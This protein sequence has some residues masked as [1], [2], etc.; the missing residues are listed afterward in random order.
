MERLAPS[1]Q[2]E[3][4]KVICLDVRI[5]N[6][7]GEERIL[8]G[9]IRPSGNVRFRGVEDSNKWSLFTMGKEGTDQFREHSLNGKVCVDG[10]F[11]KR[12][13]QEIDPREEGAEE[14]DESRVRS[15][16]GNDYYVGK[17]IEVLPTAQISE[18]YD[19]ANVF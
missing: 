9:D 1:E 6:P 17:I 18:L 4:K 19:D 2:N 7:R 16:K 15:S 13:D 14:G 11:L 8:H 12:D 10:C 3:D 5:I